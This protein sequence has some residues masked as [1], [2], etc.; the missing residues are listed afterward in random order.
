[1][2][3]VCMTLAFFVLAFFL[4]ISIEKLGKLDEKVTELQSET[5]S[6]KIEVMKSWG[7]NSL[8]LMGNVLTDISLN[9]IQPEIIASFETELHNATSLEQTFAVCDRIA[10]TLSNLIKSKYFE[11]ESWLFERQINE[12]KRIVGMP[13]VHPNSSL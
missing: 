13:T 1:M 6:L 3:R 12:Y 9:R 2:A 4:G 10:N 11:E 5:Q 7:R 8:F